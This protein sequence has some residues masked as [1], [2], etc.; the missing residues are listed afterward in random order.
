MAF[1]PRFVVSAVCVFAASCQEP[2]LDRQSRGQSEDPDPWSVW[3]AEPPRGE[4]YPVI[5]DGEPQL[6]N[7]DIV[8][9][10]LPI[11]HDICTGEPINPKG[12]DPK[13]YPKIDWEKQTDVQRGELQCVN[14][15]WEEGGPGDWDPK[16]AQRTRA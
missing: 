15:V 5:P 1:R 8:D 16:Y 11:A 13:Q 2:Q 3:K 9:A 7:G 4:E 14:G 10:D 12:G 6:Q